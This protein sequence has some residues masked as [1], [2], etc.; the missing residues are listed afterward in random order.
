VHETFSHSKQQQFLLLFHHT[1]TSI[2]AFTTS[3]SSISWCCFISKETCTTCTYTTGVDPIR[4]PVIQHIVV[5]Y[6]SIQQPLQAEIYINYTQQILVVVS[7]CW[8]T[9]RNKTNTPSCNRKGCACDWYTSDY[10]YTNNIILIYLSMHAKF[11]NK[12]THILLTQCSK[13]QQYV[14][15]LYQNKHATCNRIGRSGCTISDLPIL[16]S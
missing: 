15:V 1:K 3:H 13:Q 10:R 4:Q 6:L 9:G 8:L 5:V 11:Y 16:V 14:V 12:C 2:P 7:Y